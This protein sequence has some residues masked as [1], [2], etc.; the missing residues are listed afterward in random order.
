MMK[1]FALFQDDVDCELFPAGTIIFETGNPGDRMYIIQ[2]GEVD[3]LIGSQ[4]LET[5]GSDNLIGEMALI[6]TQIRSATA[7]TKS[8]CKLIPINKRRFTF[9]VQQH[10]YFALQVMQVLADRLRRMN[11]KG[12][13]IQLPS[14]IEVN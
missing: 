12:I 11:A 13:N 14:A 9:L 1:R 3:I 7:V 10:P 2:E 6:D 8:D 5:A 4:V